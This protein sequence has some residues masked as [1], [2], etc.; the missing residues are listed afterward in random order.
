MRPFHARVQLICLITIAAI[1]IAVSLGQLK[2]IM[3]PL[4]LAI[5][6][7]YILGPVV[8]FLVK[9]WRFPKMLGIMTSLFL[10]FCLFSIAGLLIASSVSV[11]SDKSGEYETHL[12]SLGGKIFLWL[13][14]N[15]ITWLKEHNIEIDVNQMSHFYENIPV[16]GMIQSLTNTLLDLLSNTFLILIFAIYL[17]EGRKSEQTSSP[18]IQRIETK[19][20]NYLII[21]LIL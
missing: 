17:L 20:K 15:P 3:V 13:E 2:M 21:K 11:L 6:L 5:M 14:E 9:K 16:S 10:T 19:I 18:L 12:Q 8:D 1:L 7:S 4:V